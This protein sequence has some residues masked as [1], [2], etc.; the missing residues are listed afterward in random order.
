MERTIELLAPAKDK[1]TGIAAINSGADAV[2]IGAPE[3]SARAAAGNTVSDIEKLASYARRYRVKVYAAVNT[4]IYEPELERVRN[5]IFDLCRA[6]TDAVIFQDMGIL[7]MDLPPVAL[8]ASTQCHNY[9]PEH[10]KFLSDTGVSRIILARELELAQLAEARKAASCSLECFVH[11]ALCVSMSGRCYMS[12]AAGGR[13]ANRGNCAQPCRKAYSVINQSGRP[14]DMGKYP[15]S[16]KDMNRGAYLEQ[17]I[18]AG[19]DSLK[20]EGRLKDQSYVKNITSWYRHK[21]DDILNRHPSLEKASAGTVIQNFEPDPARTFNRGFTEYFLEGR[22][23]SV[24][25][26]ATPKSSG[27]YLGRVLKTEKNRFFLNTEKQ[28]SAGD[29][30][31]FFTKT[32]ETRGIQVNRTEKG[33]IYPLSANGIFPGAELF[34]NRDAAFEKILSSA[35]IQR[36]IP[37]DMEFLETEK[38]FL[39][40]MK[41]DGLSVSAAAKI[42]AEKSYDP[43][44]N[45]GIIKKHLSKTGDS[46]FM[47]GTVTVKTDKFLPVS[48]INS[49]RRECTEKLEQILAERRMPAE[50]PVIRA[51]VPFPEKEGDFTWNISNSMAEK[52]YR[53]RGVQK[54]VPAFELSVGKQE[55]VVMETKMCLRYE[56]GKCPKYQ[57]QGK[58]ESAD[59]Y[60]IL[61]DGQ[62]RFRAEFNC[63]D[64]IMTIRQESR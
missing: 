48:F 34:R 31:F 29:G 26:S 55:S 22:K 18:L 60:Y 4:I 19:M 64:C 23:E 46:L 35:K 52:F 9:S 7:E 37:A 25:S 36:K 14:A 50:K 57:K 10:I 42:Q 3:F 6:G 16:L 58:A 5:L 63:R 43:E 61:S 24:R 13:S 11:G 30:L 21:L 39:L 41:A 20:I 44:K 45:S 1:E 15:L 40:S 53:R 49:M 8:H 59:E 47:P 32:G 56:T 17:L 62:N 33:F 27:E 2:Y 38:G 28:I 51:D 54:T 12:A